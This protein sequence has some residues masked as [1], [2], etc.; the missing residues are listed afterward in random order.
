VSSTT[1]S[2]TAALARPS[3][4]AAAAVGALVA[5]VVL[6]PAGRS[7]TTRSHALAAVGVAPDVSSNWAGYVVTGLGS[8]ATTADP[9]VAYKNVTGTW[10]VPKATCSATGQTSSSAI[11]VGI[12]GYSTGSNALEQTGT[13]S[14]CGADGKAS[15][16]AWWELV[17]DPAVS[18]KLKILPGD[19]ITGSVVVNGTHVLMQI[20]NRTRKT[21]FTKRATFATPDLT[22]AEWIAE[23]PSECSSN[24]YC[25]QLPLANFGSVTFTRIAALATVQGIDPPDQGGTITSPLWQATPIQLVPQRTRRYFGDRIERPDALTGAAGAKP[26]SVSDDGRSFGVDWVANAASG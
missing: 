4:L 11:W 5:T 2:R 13:S 19:L 15:Y 24:G 23:A 14:D 9:N 18:V 17:P 21:S 16:F 7:A 26:S 10:R 22:S 3:L 25:R 12:G 1:P 8:T 20:K 6:A